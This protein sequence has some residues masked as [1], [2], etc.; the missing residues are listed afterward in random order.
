MKTV[1]LLYLLMFPT[2]VSM[3]VFSYYP[4]LDVVI[5]AFY[6]WEPGQIE[7]F[8]GLKN[9]QDALADPLFWNSFQLVVILLVA[10]LIKMWPGIIT[11]I[12]LH[13]LA[14]DRWRYIFQVAFVIPMVIP[15][16]VWLLIW[17][18]FYEPDFGILNRF[19]TLTGGMDLLSWL[20]GTKEL[21]GVMPNIAT[22]LAPIINGPVTTLFSSVW[23][24]LT[25]G[26]VVMTCA[27]RSVEPIANLRRAVLTVGLA[28]CTYL[29]V[30][31]NVQGNSM[32]AILAFVGVVLFVISIA[33][34]SGPS[35]LLWCLWMLAGIW[36]CQERLYMLPVLVLVAEVL[37]FAVRKMTNTIA[38]KDIVKWV[39]L[40]SVIIGCL[41]V[42]FGKIWVTSTGQFEFGSPAWLG[43][44]DLVLPAI[45]FWGFPW[46]GT[47]GVLIY[48]SGLQQISTD[49]YEAAELD[50]VG[51]IRRVFSIE[52]PLI[53]T[54]VRINLIFMTIGTLTAYEFFLI[55]LG[56]A[57]GPG[58]KGMVPGLYM[59]QQ[60]FLQGK[61]GYACALG[62]VLFML[63]LLLTVI[64]QRYVKVEK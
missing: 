10:N 58:N 34:S 55:L 32:G 35:W 13:R 42:A 24:M 64:Y 30:K 48:L 45:I 46:V 26:A 37:N 22:S 17:K 8:I 4:K 38:A 1:S 53:M 50:G 43:N 14:S 54:Q 33:R 2:I 40:A 5:K 7:E 27:A 62:M 44:K 63:V 36:T 20:D 3:L 11:A 52:L 60:A 59:Y 19:L 9:F 41:F 39:G 25:F 31:T 57:G 29:L 23:G 51:P 21:P 61:F 56:A 16:L 49:V 47:V 18:S 6:R 28:V 12:A 15:G